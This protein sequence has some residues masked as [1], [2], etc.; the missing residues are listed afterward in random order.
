MSGLEEQARENAGDSVICGHMPV[1]EQYK[2][3]PK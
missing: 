1:C 3:G 2:F